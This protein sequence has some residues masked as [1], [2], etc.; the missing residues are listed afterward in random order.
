MNVD[1]AEVETFRADYGFV[2]FIVP[3][4]EHTVEASY[5]VAGFEAGC[6]MTAAGAVGTI[7]CVAVLK[8][9]SR[10]STQPSKQ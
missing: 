2:G 6:A 5:S 10:H 1:G 9:R 8:G 3:E 4:G 7:A